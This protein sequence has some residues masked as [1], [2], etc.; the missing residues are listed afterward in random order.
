MARTRTYIAGEWDGDSDAIEQIYKWNEGDKWNL[1]FVDAHGFKQCYDS[2]L[3]CTIKASLSERLSRSKTFVLVVGNNTKSARKG[4]CY[5]ANCNNKGY[6]FFTAQTTCNVDGKNYSTESFIDYECRHA[7]NAWLHDDIEGWTR[8]S[9]ERARKVYEYIT[10][11]YGIDYFNYMYTPVFYDNIGIGIMKD[12]PK[13][14]QS[15]MFDKAG[16]RSMELYNYAFRT[17]K[18]GRNVLYARTLWLKTFKVGIDIINYY[19]IASKRNFKKVY[20]F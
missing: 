6:N 4:S 11:E 14:A 19:N 18:D 10:N 7:Y 16:K 3:P 5:Y 15:L 8:Y 13:F 17:L 12:F 1:H 9:L 2:S 20:G